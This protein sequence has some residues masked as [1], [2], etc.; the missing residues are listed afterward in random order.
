M[1]NYENNYE[2]IMMWLVDYCK[3]H[4]IEI[5]FISNLDSTAKSYTFR[6]LKMIYFND[7]WFRVDEKPFLLAHEIGHAMCAREDMVNAHD[8][9][10]NKS[11]N[12]CKA[13]RFAI[14]LLKKYCEENDIFFDSV[15][16]F[17]SFFG[18]P[19]RCFYILEEAY[20]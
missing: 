3:R 2:D 16:N 5:N 17:A 11:K 7:K 15:Y 20:S 14:R 8:L 4:H 6:C 1:R 18:I 12:E 10:S 19:S 9:Y 13:N